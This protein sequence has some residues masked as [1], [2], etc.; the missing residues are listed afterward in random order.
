[1]T[2][3]DDLLG[4]GNGNA[5]KIQGVAVEAGPPTDGELVTYDAASGQFKFAA[6][7]I[8]TPPSISLASAKA[9]VTNPPT[10]AS[11]K[12]NVYAWRMPH[13]STTALHI[14]MEAPSKSASGLIPQLR[15]APS[16]NGSGNVRFQVDIA[17]ANPSGTFGSATSAVTVE[18]A[19]GVADRL[20]TTQ[21]QSL[22]GVQPGAQIDMRVARIGGD[23]T[24]TYAGDAVTMQIG[25]G[26]G[27][28]NAPPAW[29]PSD[30]S[31]LMNFYHADDVDYAPSTPGAQAGYVARLPDN[32]SSR[33]HLGAA[34]NAT[35]AIFVNDFMGAGQGA[36]TFPSAQTTRLFDIYNPD[37]AAGNAFAKFLHDGS[38]MT[39]VMYC[40]PTDPAVRNVALSTTVSTSGAGI[41]I[42]HNGT[43]DRWE[44]EIRNASAAIAT[45]TSTGHAEGSNYVVSATYSEA[46]SP[47]A[48]LRVNGVQAASSGTSAAPSSLANSYLCMGRISGALTPFIGGIRVMLIYNRVLS[49]SELATVESNIAAL[50]TPRVKRRIWTVGDSITAAVLWQQQVYLRSLNSN[51]R[52]DWLGTQLAGDISLFIDRQHDGYPANTIQQI[53][54]H[55]DGAALGATPTDVFV[56]AG[57]NNAGGDITATVNLYDTLVQTIRTQK[58][59][60][61]IWVCRPPRRLDAQATWTENYAAALVTYA[62]SNGFHYVAT[63]VASNA[64]IQGDL[65][66]PTTTGYQTMGNVVANA[67]GY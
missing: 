63:D 46:A 52:I 27:V 35:S 45:L 38:G 2:W 24:D 4:S 41:N 58:S 53:T 23:A 13:G 40:K 21:F 66:H 5:T 50:A 61:A 34:S 6:P 28:F 16:T 20:V 42:Q 49:P 25:L 31:G 17:W 3:L 19:P 57:T 15:W 11:Y 14:S 59:N 60:P 12:G 10:W 56:L 33:R 9:D 47:K 18:A 37:T 44:F 67:L 29:A 43:S 51:E 7:T 30:I 54:T 55:I 48:T 22:S 32:A 1:M 65:I 64:E 26:I 62:A 36:V 8:P 39:V